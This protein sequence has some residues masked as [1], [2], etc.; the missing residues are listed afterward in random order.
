MA[1]FNQILDPG[2]IAGG[3]GRPLE[4]VGPKNRSTSYLG[5]RVSI[6]LSRRVVSD[7]RALATD[8]LTLFAIPQGFC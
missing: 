1:D 2:D 5:R 8:G 7:W 6:L 3:I 4:I